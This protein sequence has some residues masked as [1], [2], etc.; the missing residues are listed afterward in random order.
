[1]ATSYANLINQIEQ[2]LQDSGNAEFDTTELGDR[3]QQGLRYVARYV[4]HI[5]RVPYFIESRTGSATATAAGYLVDT[6]ETQFIVAN[7]IGKVIRNLNDNTWAIVVTDGS[8][9]TSKLK[10]S[11]DIMVSGEEYEMYNKECVSNKQINIEDV[12]D[13]LWVDKVEFP[14]GTERSF[15]LLG[16]ILTLGIDFTPDDTNDADAKKIVHVFFAKRHKVSQLTDLLGAVD[17]GAGYSEGDTTMTIDEITTDEIVEEDQE[18]TVAGMQEIYTVRAAVTISGSQ[19][20]VTFYPGLEADVAEDAVVTFALSTFEGR[21]GRQ[22]EALFV[23]Y[24]AAM[25]ASSKAT[26]YINA[27]PKGGPG[28]P[29]RFQ[30]W[31]QLT[32]Q[33]VQRDL[34]AL[35]DPPTSKVLTRAR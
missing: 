8:N 12:E 25:A 11:R 10:L 20:D 29:G 27:I 31:A 1:M 13:Y 6:G 22:L 15:S 26:K 34:M 16:T 30:S 18:F 28:V 2:L 7:D 32:L 14:I 17:L 3:F 33:R 4:P 19:A 24:V 35:A 5:V 9:S 21:Y 23:D